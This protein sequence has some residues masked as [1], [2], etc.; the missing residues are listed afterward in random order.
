M[1]PSVRPETSLLTTLDAE[2]TAFE[3]FTETLKTEQNALIAGDIDTLTRIAPIKQ[4][5]IEQLNRIAEQRLQQL[6]ALG[7]PSNRTGMEAW[8]KATGEAALVA[9]HTVLKVAA[10][11]HQTNALNGE[12]LQTRLEHNKQALKAIFAAMGKSSLYGPDGQPADPKAGSGMSRG[13]I[14][15]A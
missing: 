10:L 3:E 11:A 8:A 12:L 13:V 4:Q 2:I 15:K 1:T 5:Q 9:W 6:S 7:F 14:G